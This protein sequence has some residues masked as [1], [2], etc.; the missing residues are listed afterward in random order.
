M[1]LHENYDHQIN[2]AREGHGWVDYHYFLSKFKRKDEY[3][4]LR[5]LIFDVA[6]GILKVVNVD[7]ID[8][9]D[10]Y[11]VNPNGDYSLI[12]VDEDLFDKDVIKEIPNS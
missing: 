2:L 5:Q 1:T 7:F 10:S 3:L 11:S 9:T 8:K 12:L 4:P 6:A